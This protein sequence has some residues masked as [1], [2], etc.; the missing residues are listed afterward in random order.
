VTGPA[1]NSLDVVPLLAPLPAD[2][3]SQIGQQCR[4]RR[5]APHETIIDRSDAGRDVFFVVEGRV[6]VVNF[7]ASGR[8]I[9]FDDLGIGSFFGELAAIDGGSRSASV[10][11]LSSTLVAAMPPS[12]LERVAMEEPAIATALL[13]HLAKMVRRSTERIMDLSTL[14]ANNRVQ[15]E[16]LRLARDGLLPDGTATIRPIPVHADIASRVSTTRETVARV[17]GD[18]NRSGIVQRQGDH[19]LVRDF[20]ALQEMVEEVRGEP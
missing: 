20:E 14:A 9:S 5:Y 11:A 4:F 19:L 12:V 10:V 8:E 3:R 2:R 16:V 6:R 7:S 18:L 17:F 13:R 1:T 15:A